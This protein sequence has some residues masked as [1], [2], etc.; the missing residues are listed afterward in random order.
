ML[1]ILYYKILKCEFSTSI[2]TSS[3]LYSAYKFLKYYV[4]FENMSQI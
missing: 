3:K 2:E 1:N 4:R